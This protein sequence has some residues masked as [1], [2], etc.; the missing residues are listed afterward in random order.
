MLSFED[1]F[2][3]LSI[4]SWIILTV[5]VVMFYLFAFTNEVKSSP[6][7]V[8]EKLSKEKF[9]NSEKKNSSL[10]K[11]LNFNTSWCGYSVRFQPEWEKFQKE[12]K[13]RNDLSNVRA[14]DIKCDNA[15][16][17]QM[18]VE[19]EV[20]GFPTIIIEKDGKK[21]DYSGAR[22]TEALIETVKNL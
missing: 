11:V 15:D 22:T 17:K 19:Y 2:Y 20:P 9:S 8:E 16:N 12:V 6:I 10:I 21:T 5:L 14:Y 18:C 7:P 3:G 13:A 4:R 1:K